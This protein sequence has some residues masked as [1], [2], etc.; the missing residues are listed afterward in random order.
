MTDN[1]SLKLIFSTNKQTRYGASSVG[2]FADRIKGAATAFILAKLF[3]RKFYID[4]SLPEEVENIFRVQPKF[5]LP[6]SLHHDGSRQFKTLDLIDIHSRN[7]LDYELKLALKYRHKK[8]IFGKNDMYLIHANFFDMSLFSAVIDDVFEAFGITQAEN[9]NENFLFRTI[10][11]E[12]F[13]YANPLEKKPPNE[14]LT[15][16]R[17]ANDLLVGVHF[18]TGANVNWSDPEMDS[19]DNWRL[20]VKACQTFAAQNAGQKIGF[21]VAS[22]NPACR[23]KISDTL[24]REFPVFTFS[25]EIFHLERSALKLNTQPPLSD[26]FFEHSC[27]SIADVVI[28]G[29]GGFAQTAS[30]IGGGKLYLYSDLI[31]PVDQKRALSAPKKLA[32]NLLTDRLKRLLIR[33]K[34]P[35]RC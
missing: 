7:L 32:Q 17:N 35:F 23:Q 1:T 31:A 5:K 2:G 3:N 28:C 10:F 27:L 13:Y 19:E 29:S 12:L 16:I 24:H 33:A 14:A 21:I 8:S 25:S 18:R 22:D 4:W 30:A 11:N 9:Q 15:A 6:A 26:V 20:V 34:Y